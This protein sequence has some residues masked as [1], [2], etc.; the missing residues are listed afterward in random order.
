M[1]AEDAKDN[2]ETIQATPASHEHLTLE[3]LPNEII[4]SIAGMLAIG[5][6]VPYNRASLKTSAGCKH[7]RR[8]ALRDLRRLCMVSKSIIFNAQKA[9]YRNILITNP[10]T[11]ILLY[12][13]FLENPEL[14]IYVKRMSLDID[15]G[16]PDIPFPQPVWDHHKLVCYGYTIHL[17]PLL[18]CAQHGLGEH[19]PEIV[20][21]GWPKSSVIPAEIF[22]TI[23][24][25]VL[26]HTSNL[27]SLDVHIHPFLPLVKSYNQQEMKEQHWEELGAVICSLW[28]E[29]L[30][31]LSRV[32]KLQLTGNHRPLDEGAGSIATARQ[33][34]STR[35]CR[36]FLKLPNL[37]QLVWI[38]CTRAL[39][40]TH[41]FLTVSGKK[42]HL[43]PAASPLL[44]NSSALY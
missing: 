34:F 20:K 7:E 32:K 16:R 22:Y 37:E 39:F 29:V 15:R 42:K 5:I 8:N 28:E 24:F 41:P 9:L 13:T 27:E 23:Q 44:R 25:R 2:V 14:G 30:P 18:S 11:L 6:D 19:F 40:N 3:T 1:T 26:G 17:N 38:N 12:R 10:N 35:I 4:S 33:L 36:L 21:E 43:H 31:C